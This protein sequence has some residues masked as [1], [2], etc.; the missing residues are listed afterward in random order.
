L[1]LTG[2]FFSAPSIMFNAS[3]LGRSA[4]EGWI[5]LEI[6]NVDNLICFPLGG[7]MVQIECSLSGMLNGTEGWSGRLRLGTG[8]LTAPGSC[9]IRLLSGDMERCGKWLRIGCV[10]RTI[11]HN[12]RPLH[13]NEFN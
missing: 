2:R 7:E 8:G 13:I 3:V 9:Q 12:H 1:E 11:V 10:S 6:V 4:V 5:R